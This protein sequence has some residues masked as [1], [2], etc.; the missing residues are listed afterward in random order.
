MS[1]YNPVAA[2]RDLDARNKLNQAKRELQKTL[3][4]GKAAPSFDE[5]T[6]IVDVDP[7]VVVR[8]NAAK[9]SLRE[10]LSGDKPKP[11]LNAA[12]S[13]DEARNQ[14]V[15]T[16]SRG[17]APVAAIPITETT[18]HY[19]V[20]GSG[21]K[22]AST[23]TEGSIQ[24]LNEAKASWKKTMSGEA[25]E[26]PVAIQREPSQTLTASQQMK[27][28]ATQRDAR[29]TMANLEDATKIAMAKDELVR[30]MKQDG[31][32]RNQ[33]EDSSQTNTPKCVPFSGGFPITVRSRGRTLEQLLAE[34]S[35]K[36]VSP[37]PAVSSGEDA[38]DNGDVDDG[39]DWS[40]SQAQKEP[41]F[42]PEKVKQ[43]LVTWAMV[44]GKVDRR[45]A[46]SVFLVQNGRGDS[47]DD[48]EVPLATI[49]KDGEPQYQEKLLDDAY[50]HASGKFN[51][52]ANRSLQN[53]VILLK[54]KAGHSLSDE[55][56]DYKMRHMAAASPFYS[57]EPN[58]SEIDLAT[59]KMD[60]T[61]QDAILALHRTQRGK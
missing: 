32:I 45:K 46:K 24:K 5:D 20:E 54:K 10:T 38:D 28:N 15:K 8:L 18:M 19:M 16:M 9:S 33:T 40:P 49:G 43:D 13:P 61:Y 41:E 4:G 42:S 58:E 25:T 17:K 48:Y 3:S 51:N 6:E 50:D 35:K 53:R 23:V 56:A 59:M 7:Q 11:K 36:V 21:I 2:G 34:Q 60:S 37:S 26:A 27:F 1:S 14:L 12:S 57:V 39:G 47:A 55:Q 31:G 30:T 44:G 29:G 22:I 52:I